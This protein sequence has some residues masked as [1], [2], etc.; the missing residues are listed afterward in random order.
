MGPTV[1]ILIADDDVTCRRQLELTLADEGY[2]VVAACDGHEAWDRLQEKDAPRLAILD[3]MMPGLDGLELCRKLRALPGYRSMYLILLTANNRKQEVSQ[4]LKAGADDYI[5]KPFDYQELLA[6]V[7]VG[8]RMLQLQQS[9]ADRVRDLEDALSR[10]RQLQG[11]LPICCYCKNIRDDK[12]YW[13]QL[14]HYV[15]ANSNAQFSHG[16]CPTCFE[17]VVEPQLAEARRTRTTNQESG[18]AGLGRS[19]GADS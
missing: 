8:V 6:R 5:T 12:N 15:A 17:K 9:L 14:E 1:K 3:W 2:P 16:S 10:V 7:Q 18:I 4:G 13:Q 19:L 11:L